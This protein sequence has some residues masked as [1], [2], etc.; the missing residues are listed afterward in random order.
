MKKNLVLT[1]I[2]LTIC[3]DFFNLGLIYPIFTSLV[4][5]GN[6]DLVSLHASQFFKNTLFAV[7]IA[8]FPFGQFLG[9][10]IIGYLSDQHGRRKLL[11]ASLIG[12]VATL[13]V[14]ALGVTFGSL[15]LLLL[16][17]FVGGLMAGNMTLAYASLADFSAPEE[18]VKNFALI[19]LVIGIG[20][21]FGPYVAGILANPETHSLAGPA[22]PFLV[23]TLLAFVNLLLVYWKFPETVSATGHKPRPAKMFLLSVTKLWKGFQQRAMRPYLW[24][25]L[26]MT[27]SNLVFVQFVGPFA[28]ERFGLG[29]TEVGYLYANIGASVAIGHLFL[30]RQLA[31]FPSNTVLLWS[32][33]A[34]AALLIVL[35]FSYNIVFLHAVTALIML[36]CAVAYTNSMALV[37][38]QAA[39]DQQG[40]T[41]GVA[42][43]VQSCSEF[44]PATIL[45][46]V[47]F[48]SQSVPL[49]AASLLAGGAYLILGSL[50]SKADNKVKA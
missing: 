28:I 40:E 7:L 48:I 45:G 36:A 42:V 34:L 4:F 44:L 25:L 32:L 50:M 16:G 24:I 2:L 22:L 47:A 15:S 10:P 20:F 12:T 9:A 23:A 14:C 35:L 26:L 29:V 17:R 3:L 33:F 1:A 27:S 8:A 21:A 18:K 37:S 43:S 38:N 5:E 6:G 19:P 49:F 13:F 11:I 41:M 39:N 30:T 31:R 46:L